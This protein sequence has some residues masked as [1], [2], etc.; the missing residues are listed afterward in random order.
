MQKQIIYLIGK[1][2]YKKYTLFLNNLG[3]VIDFYSTIY[4]SF[5]TFRSAGNA[6]R[7]IFLPHIKSREIPGFLYAFFYLVVCPYLNGLK[8]LSFI[9]ILP[10][11]KA[12]GF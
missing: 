9:D 1:D 2:C 6:S 11:A 5:S 10:M 4:Y 3:K 7:R 8:F 12:R